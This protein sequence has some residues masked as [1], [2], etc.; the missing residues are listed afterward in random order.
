MLIETS[1]IMVC[2]LEKSKTFTIY[3]KFPTNLQEPMYKTADKWGQI[4]L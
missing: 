3:N 1:I 2:H 4:T